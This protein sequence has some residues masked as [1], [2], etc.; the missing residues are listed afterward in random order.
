MV[1]LAGFHPARAGRR[2][3]RHKFTRGACPSKMVTRGPP[4]MAARAK[5]MAVPAAT[6]RAQSQARPCSMPASSAR[7]DRQAP[8]IAGESRRSGSRGL[9]AQHLRAWIANSGG[10]GPAS[11]GVDRELGRG[12]R[13]FTGG[14]ARGVRPV[15]L[16]SK[17]KTPWHRPAAPMIVPRHEAR[18]R[19]SAGLTCSQH[20]YMLCTCP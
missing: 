12:V 9:V 13:L 19:Q 18:A 3:R 15:S 2:V 5:S 6:A 1:A 14:P 16:P 4:A 8:S 7:C 10:G 20:V 17:P 11:E